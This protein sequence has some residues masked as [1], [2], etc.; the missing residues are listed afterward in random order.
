MPVTGGLGFIGSNLCL[1]LV[2][3]GAAVTV[4]DSAVPGCGANRFNLNKVAGLVRILDCDIGDTNRLRNEVPTPDVVFNVAGEISHSM[5][6]SHPERDLEI[7]TCSQLRFLRFCLQQF[8]G[9][10]V[11][12]AAPAALWKTSIPAG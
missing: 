9:I 1:R 7:N 10:R 8:P 4:I 6:M 11:V 12:Y 3:E 5:S 2:R